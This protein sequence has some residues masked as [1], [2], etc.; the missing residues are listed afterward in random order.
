MES[1]PAI[2]ISDDEEP[3]PEQSHSRPLK[4]AQVQTDGDNQTDFRNY[5]RP[6]FFSMHFQ[7]TSMQSCLVG[8]GMR[9]RHR[10]IKRDSMLQHSKDR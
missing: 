9:F 7:Y 8:G 10:L 1:I 5:T 4:P 2:V 6:Y 3:G